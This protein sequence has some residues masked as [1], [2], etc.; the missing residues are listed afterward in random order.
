MR[1]MR[2]H[3]RGMRHMN[4]EGIKAAAMDAGLTALVAIP[5]AAVVGAITY[6]VSKIDYGT[7][8]ADATLT[9]GE[10][11]ALAV[12]AS[13]LVIGGG[14]LMVPKLERFAR[15]HIAVGIGAPVALITSM[16]IARSMAPARVTA[17]VR[18]AAQPLVAEAPAPA[19][20]AAAPATAATAGMYYPSG[21]MIGPSSFQPAAF[22]SSG[23]LPAYSTQF[24]SPAFVPGGR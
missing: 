24:Q 10:K 6:G 23:A 9:N 14:L 2:S 15:A 19:L 16:A 21:S 1:H 7:Q 4:P 3:R 12:A 8:A 18:A 5:A 13:T 22:S 17:P 11:M 20:P